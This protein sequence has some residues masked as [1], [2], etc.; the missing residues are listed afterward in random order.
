MHRSLKSVSGKLQG[1]SRGFKEYFRWFERDFRRFQRGFRKIAE[2]FQRCDEAEKIWDV[3][4]WRM[5]RKG[6]RR[7]SNK[8][9]L[10][11][12]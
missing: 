8:D 10:S 12:I 4:G 7:V 2:K 3:Y 5:N 9:R 1:D 11:F 6:V